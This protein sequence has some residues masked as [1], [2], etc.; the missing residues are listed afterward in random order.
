VKEIEERLESN[1]SVAAVTTIS[2]P[3]PLGETRF[4]FR[5]SEAAQ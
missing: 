2:A 1:I 5:V 3:M 4:P